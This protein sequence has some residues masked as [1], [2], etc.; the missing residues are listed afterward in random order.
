[1]KACWLE[2]RNIHYLKSV[3]HVVCSDISL[4][5]INSPR[6]SRDATFT[7]VLS[8]FT[9]AVE[10]SLFPE[11]GVSLVVFK[12]AFGTTGFHFVCSFLS[13]IY[14]LLLSFFVWKKTQISPSLTSSHHMISLLYTDVSSHLVTQTLATFEVPLMTRKWNRFALKV[15]FVNSNITFYI[16]IT[17][18]L[19]TKNYV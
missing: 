16:D 19:M 12:K 18:L 15:C 6:K 4:A 5:F 1:M 14:F 9:K 2:K 11:T 8:L 13:N 10:T 3:E 17:L 7:T